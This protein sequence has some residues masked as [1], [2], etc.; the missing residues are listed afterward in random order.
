MRRR[1]LGSDLSMTLS[2]SFIALNPCAKNS[3]AFLFLLCRPLCNQKKIIMKKQGKKS[4]W[5]YIGEV[6][7]YL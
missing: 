5:D 2:T 1:L 4:N 6:Q 7:T 3:A